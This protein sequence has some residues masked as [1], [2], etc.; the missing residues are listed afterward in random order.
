MSEPERRSFTRLN[1]QLDASPAHTRSSAAVSSDELF[2]S[3]LELLADASAEGQREGAPR[4]LL[5]HALR[6]LTQLL[7]SCA[8]A[9][10][11]RALLENV[12]HASPG[13]SRLAS[14][15]LRALGNACVARTREMCAPRAS[16]LLAKAG[17][18]MRIKLKHG[19][20]VGGAD[21]LNFS[22]WILLRLSEPHAAGSAAA[23]PAPGD[24]APSPGAEGA[25]EPRPLWSWEAS[26]GDVRTRLELC[27]R[28]ADGGL[29]LRHSWGPARAES[30]D[31]AAE[32]DDRAPG[33]GGGRGEGGERGVAQVCHRTA[34]RLPRGAW[35][36]VVVEVS[37][38]GQAG[39]TQQHANW[40]DLNWF[41]GKREATENRTAEQADTRGTVRVGI[42]GAP[43]VEVRLTRPLPAPPADGIRATCTLGGSRPHAHP[44]FAHIDIAH[45]ADAAQSTPARASSRTAAN[46]GQ[47]AGQSAASPAIPGAKQLASDTQS[48]NS[49]TADSQTADTGAT[50]IQQPSPFLIEVTSLVFTDRL[51]P[52]SA[53]EHVWVSLSTDGETL[54]AAVLASGVVPTH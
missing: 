11:V 49:Q 46:I 25:Q 31:G 21:T 50:G 2:A 26:A 48:A 41:G 53:R 15:L 51:L 22:C 27:L 52:P 1:T 47:P 18:R 4:E 32:G 40:F 14:E 5:A 20:E 17:A 8:R 43:A 7:S 28:S 10:H 19:V 12:C 44:D 6:V 29:E 33:G 24:G 39:G 45:A 42:N 36:M 13:G 30:R 23:H 35:T 16:V 34:L 54:G 9:H 38:G 37:G 3:V